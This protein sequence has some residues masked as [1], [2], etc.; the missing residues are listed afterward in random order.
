[1]DNGKLPEYYFTAINL[2]NTIA[3]IDKMIWSAKPFS[4]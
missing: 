3:G 1:M 2:F 4:L